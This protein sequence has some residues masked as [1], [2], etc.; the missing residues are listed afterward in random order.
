MS[1]AFGSVPLR[2]FVIVW[3]PPELGGGEAGT[4]NPVSCLEPSWLRPGHAA[5]RCPHRRFAPVRELERRETKGDQNTLGNFC[6]EV[7]GW[8]KPLLEDTDARPAGPGQSQEPREKLHF[9]YVSRA[10]HRGCNRHDLVVAPRQ[11]LGPGF[12]SSGGRDDGTVFLRS[13]LALPHQSIPENL[14]ERR[15]L[16]PSGDESDTFRRCGTV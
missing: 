1:K 10:W 3:S 11:R 9:G 15:R 5:R 8:A 6:S 14:R 16:R 2:S 12:I 13:K 7:R 4:L